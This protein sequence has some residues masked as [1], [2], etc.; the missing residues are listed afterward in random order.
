MS[1]INLKKLHITDLV[2]KSLADGVVT[3]L[4]DWSSQS[5]KMEQMRTELKK[6]VCQKNSHNWANVSSV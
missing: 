3:V 1:V 4:K 5:P 6:R 2:Q